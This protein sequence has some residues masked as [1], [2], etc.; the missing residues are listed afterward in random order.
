MTEQTEQTEQPLDPQVEA[1]RKKLLRLLLLSG[2]IM[3]V[4]FLAVFLGIVYKV[5]QNTTT[6]ITNTAE[7]VIDENA[8]LISAQIDGDKVMITLKMAD[9]STQIRVYNN[10]ELIQKITIP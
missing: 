3:I 1:I 10:S 8:E 7:W 4:G 2:V 5:N 6:T 9:G